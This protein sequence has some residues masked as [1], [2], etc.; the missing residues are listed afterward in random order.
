MSSK[1]M[2]YDYKFYILFFIILLCVIGNALR[3]YKPIKE[4][5]LD[6]GNSTALPGS[7]PSSIFSPASSPVSTPNF[8][9]FLPFTYIEN[10]LKPNS[11]TNPLLIKKP[12][13]FIDTWWNA[14]ARYISELIYICTLNGMWLFT[15]IGVGCAILIA[16]HIIWK[17]IQALISV[18]GVVFG[19]GR[20]SGLAGGLPPLGQMA[21]L[22]VL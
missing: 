3:L 18:L 7:K 19:G 4:N 15:V 16:C 10:N 9:L 14:Y 13:S 6:F 5:F 17:G 20:G 12:Q 11:K 8:N 1:S 2:K 22:A 21:K